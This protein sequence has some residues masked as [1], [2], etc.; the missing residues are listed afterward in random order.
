M[1]ESVVN[2]LKHAFR[3]LFRYPSFTV[4]AISALTLGIG[5]STA[6]F[7]VVNTVLLKPA[8]F[9]NPERTVWLA[10]TTPNGPD[11]NCSD[12]KFNLLRQQT[13]VLEDVNRPGLRKGQPDGRRFSSACTG[14]ASHLRIFFS[15]RIAHRARSRLH[16]R[17]GSP[18]R[19]S[20]G[21]FE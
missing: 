1:L 2:D 20:C 13:S 21:G 4:T 18:R 17:R 7:S 8:R 10:A 16:S 6:V 5:A 14:R 12:P 11:Y 3:G 15:L 9:A 19:P